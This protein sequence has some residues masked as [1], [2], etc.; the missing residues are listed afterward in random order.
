M[1]I[2]V[3]FICMLFLH[4]A[5]DYYLQGILANLK[6]RSWWEKNAPDSLYSH[7]YI[8][9][10]FMHSASWSFM[11]MLPLLVR[12]AFEPPV[13]FAV[14]WAVNTVIHG[15]VD[16]LKANKR[17]I[18]LIHDQCIHLIQIIITLGFFLIRGYL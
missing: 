6:Q 16:D 13:S 2:F 5:D 18:N 14:L 4:I 9:A 11:T 8:M 12:F 10:L 3:L 17:K 7:D 1:E 15:I